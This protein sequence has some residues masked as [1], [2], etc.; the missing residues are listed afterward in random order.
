M[1]Q[2]Q[3]LQGA[4]KV[5]ELAQDVQVAFYRKTYAH[6]A[7]AVLLFILVEALFFQIPAIVNFAFS[8]AEG[9]TWLILLGVFMFATSKAESMAMGT[10]DRNTQYAALFLFVVAEA[11]IFIPLIGIALMVA[12]EGGAELI[13]Q[14]AIVTLALFGGLSAAVLLTKKDFSFLKTG[15][16]IG[17]FIALGLIIAGTLFGF[18]LGLWFSV[19]MVVLASGAILYQT[20]SMVHKY[21]KD[22][23]VAASLGL[24]GS[25]MLLFWYVLSIFMRD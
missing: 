25:L 8:L 3:E 2:V 9:W 6:V 23:Y 7:G 11:F 4:P 16:V 22:Q 10:T 1:E 20:S 12:Q 15:L 5:G 24:F 21:N 13:N 19:G 14:A 18:N 17:F